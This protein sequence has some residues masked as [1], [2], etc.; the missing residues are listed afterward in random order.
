MYFYD[1]A[2]DMTINSREAQDKSLRDQLLEAHGIRILDC[3]LKSGA[4]Y[5]EFYAKIFVDVKENI[6]LTRV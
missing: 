6:K 5:D 1:K 4:N 3:G 2:V